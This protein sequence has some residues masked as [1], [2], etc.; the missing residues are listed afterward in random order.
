MIRPDRVNKRTALGAV[1]LLSFFAAGVFKIWRN[2]YNG[3]V[4]QVKRSMGICREQRRDWAY[5]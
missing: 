4:D 5:F 2:N 1:L 3:K